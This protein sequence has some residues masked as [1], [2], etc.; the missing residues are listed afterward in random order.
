[1]P[2]SLKGLHILNTRPAHQAAV[3]SLALQN[4]GA[5]VTELALMAIQ[6]RSLSAADERLLMEL[7]RYDAAFFVSANAAKLGLDAVANYWAQWPHRLPAYA[8]GEGS[9]TPLREAGLTVYTPSQPDSEGLLL[10]PEWQQATGKK[11]LIFRGVGGRELLRETLQARGASVDMIE[12]YHRE[13]PS[14][15]QQQWSQLSTSHSTIDVVILSSPAALQHWQQ[16]AGSAALQPL[17][18]VVSPRLRQQADALGARVCEAKSADTASL[19]SAL[20][21]HFQSHHFR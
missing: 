3:L 16:L 17:W 10:M 6:P 15:S 13:L 5:R 2:G 7:D 1:M 4:A 18:L 8:V 14:T 9:A 21:H 11:V 19:L 12:L 20:Q